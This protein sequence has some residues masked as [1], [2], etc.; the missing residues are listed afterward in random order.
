MTETDP[1]VEP[2]P[3]WAAAA[4]EAEKVTP[5]PP[6]RSRWQ[7]FRWV[8]V[9][10]LFAALYGVGKWTGLLD[11]LDAETIRRTVSDA[12][13]WGVVLYVVIFSAGELIH[14]PGMLFVAAGILA[15]GRLAGFFVALVGAVTS[16]SVSFWVVRGIGGKALARIDRP[17]MRKMLTRLHARPVVTIVIL[18]AVFWISPPLTYALALTNIRFRDYLV[19]SALGLLVP[20]GLAALVF[21]LIFG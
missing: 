8:A 18:R 11:D 12:G 9:I 15:Y 17:F 20:V 2:P 10:V 3:P 16:V 4:E 13:P 5:P 14:V 6:H 7:R 1:E 21:D 19:G